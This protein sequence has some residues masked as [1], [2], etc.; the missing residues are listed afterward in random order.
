MI[1]FLKGNT[2]FRGPAR[3]AKKSFE[4]ILRI[5]LQP[6]SAT[7]EFSPS[8]GIFQDC[9]RDHPRVSEDPY[10]NA[11]GVGELEALQ[12]VATL[13]RGCGLPLQAQ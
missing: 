13:R 12:A 2:D 8:E 7:K 5:S 3:T 1:P 6:K 11:E 4:G 10:A 9:S